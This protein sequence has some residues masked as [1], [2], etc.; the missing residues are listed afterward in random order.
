MTQGSGDH[1]TSDH[2]HR[3][4]GYQKSANFLIPFLFFS[5]SFVA[6]LHDAFGCIPGLNHQSTRQPPGAGDGASDEKEVGVLEPG[7]S[8]KR[9]LAGGQQ[10]VYQIRLSADQFLKT[11]VEQ[12]GINVVVQV[13]GPAGKQIREFDSEIR[14]HGQESASLLAEVTGD[15]RLIVRP[16][17]QE[18]PPG[19][20]EIRIA[21]LRVAT[22]DD[23]ALQ[24]ADN[25]IK[26]LLELDSAGKYDEALPLTERVLEIRGKIL[27][28]D[29]RDVAAIISFLADLYY[30]KGDYAK[31]APLYQRALDI[32]QKALG[33]EHPHVAASLNNLANLY[34]RLGD[35]ARAEPMHQRALAIWEK[36]LGPEHPDVADVLNNLAIF[37]DENGKYT[38]A[39]ALH[40]RALSIRE[41]ALGGEHSYVAESLNNLAIIYSIRSQY[42]KA[43][44]LYLRALAIREKAHGPEHPQVSDV[45]NNLA[46]LYKNI[47]EHAKA[48]PLYQRALRIK[49]KSLGRDHPSVA[50]SL[51]NLARLY[52]DIGEYA[53]AE[54]LYQRA[55]A[56][57]VKALGAE[58]P[59]V[60]RVLYNL[61]L[62]HRDRGE[63]V[64][65]EPLYR[66][67]LAIWEK[68][69]GP[70]HPDLARSLY[71]LANLYC[72]RG[73]YAKAEP[74]YQRSL[75]IWEK[76]LGTQHPNLAESLN[77]LAVLCLA[78]GD[79]AQAIEHQSRANAISEHN[80]EL[81]LAIG[82]ERQKLAYLATLSGQTDRTVSL[83]LRSAPNDPM[84][85]K[86]AITQILQR[87]GRA[88]DATSE[89]LNA[90]RSRF[91][92][93]DQALLDQLTDARS[94]LAR[95]VLDGPQE[96]TGEQ[97]RDR[98]KALEDQAEKFESDISRRSSEF[99][100]QSLPVMLA[101]VQAAIPAGAAL[102][103]F[104][105]Y[106][107]FN[108]KAG[109]ADEAYG[110]PRY[111]VYVLRHE[112]EIQWKELGDVNIIDKAI[113]AL[114]NALRNPKR[115][116]VKSIA[117][118]VD[119]QVFQP[120]RP[121]IGES[122]KLL[123][124]PDG[125]L[126]LIP[127]AALVDERGRYL[128]ERYSIS[129][130]AS[131]R[132]LLRLQV[133][134]ESKSGPLV[135]A[136]PDFGG[137]SQVLAAR[138]GNHVN[139]V[140]KGRTKEQV[141]EES[142]AS[143]FSQ[144]YFSPLP[145]TAQEGDA[146]RALLPETTLLT[147][148][149][150]SKSA[151][152][153]VRSPALL[154]IATHGFFLKD[155]KLMPSE[156]RGFQA[157]NDSPQRLLR[158]TERSGIPIESPLLRS[159]LAL[160]GA[161]E[162]R[163]DGILTALEVTGLN[164]WGTKLVVLSACDTG[165]GEVKNGDG[166]HGLR[167]AL[168]LAGSESQVMSLWAVSDKATREL[169][170]SYYRLLQ[171]GEGRG[172]ALRRVQLEMLKRVNRRHPYYWAGFIQ[173]GEWVN[174]EG[175]RNR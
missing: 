124:S 132:D 147:K 76:A 100:A 23:R 41:K 173:S 174:L 131:G 149:E 121:L 138:R 112:G 104:A 33:P 84:A 169:M 140:R 87:K 151:L 17:D 80:L 133:L 144:I 97:Y 130:L 161:N 83:H 135:V 165:V 89:T 35:Y 70:E 66:R 99:R 58:H 136:N 170:V 171:Q 64:K 163:D 152:S 27:G 4:V 56:I 115:T 145:Y 24:E 50:Q 108:A 126:N 19:R 69:F 78:K 139:D 101:A 21:E 127:F 61:A 137:R 31:A 46:I 90:L 92:T 166:V 1:P 15:Y 60:A 105:S 71:G 44:P 88:L 6:P 43:E 5:L 98:I 107:P 109:R 42:A 157:V 142:A 148:R 65:A 120:L 67:A 172:E 94:Q 48:E 57:R 59:D 55:L 114:R 117:R 118:A 102:I 22:N 111:V 156:G 129:Y 113:V 7:K 134:R 106:H 164:L 54:P 20:Y 155:S 53:K 38:K 160:A 162:H 45:L 96:M 116:D 2:R 95:L 77:G 37:Y 13:L 150:A 79:I 28:P 175:E 119:R 123:I 86:L 93:E 91:N 18:A 14:N 103:E 16:K 74:L 141:E 8:I 32:F 52:G 10:H 12:D 34:V 68:T 168:V 125:L 122:T 29:H 154:H 158:E 49:E 25:L 26:K 9:E 62:L 85:H 153:Q 146:L 82:S 75:V 11:I 39:E 128:V 36:A 167:R 110:K 51:N 81:N 73:E 30:Y 72:G 3:Q 63:Y 47:G 159:G 40:Q 143:A